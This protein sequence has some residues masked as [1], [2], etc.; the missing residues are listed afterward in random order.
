MKPP[1]KDT[2]KQSVSPREPFLGA[3]ASRLHKGWYSRGYLPHFDHPGLV[4]MIT[5][6]L[7]DALPASRRA[8]WEELLKIKDDLNRRER[9]ETYLDAS[10]GSCS[11]RVMGVLPN[12]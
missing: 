2:S 9:I 12:S 7:H 5:F 4:Q 10:Y 3:Q 1:P 11:L 6:R 8:E